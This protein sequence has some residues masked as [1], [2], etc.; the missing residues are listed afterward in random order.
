MA[1]AEGAI[2]VKS[3]C[4]RDKTQIK[5]HVSP[6]A[7]MDTG[8]RTVPIW[9]RTRVDGAVTSSSS[10]RKQTERRR[11]GPQGALQAVVC[12]RHQNREVMQKH[13]HT[14]TLTQDEVMRT[15]THTC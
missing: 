3:H 8:E 2:E 10:G 14:H 7:R 6:A 5:M 4:R 11:A 12:P 15:H 1:G 9:V 13:E